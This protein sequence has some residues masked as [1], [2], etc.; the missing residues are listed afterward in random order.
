MKLLKEFGVKSLVVTPFSNIT[1]QLRKDLEE[2]FGSK[3]VGQLG[4]RR[5]KVDRLFTVANAQSASKVKPNTSE[6]DELS[7]CQV[8][9]FDESHMVPAE[10]FK[11]ICLNGVAMNAKKRFFL[12][13]TQTRTDGSELML[14]GITGPVV[15][16]KT[17]KELA[18]QKFLKKIKARIFKVP[19]ARP[20][21][22]DPN[23]ETRQ[24]L[25]ENPNVARL[26]ATLAEKAFTVANRQ[27]VIL[28]EEYSQFL[29]LKNFMNVPYKFA[30]GTVT[31]EQKKT[32]PEEYW[33]CDPEAIVDEFNRGDLPCIIGTTAIA[34]G[35]DIKPTG[36][37]INIQGGKSEIK[38]KQG[39]GRG[40]R[41]VGPEELWV[42]DFKVVGS[43]TLENHAESR[44]GIYETLSEEKVDEI[45]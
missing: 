2:A 20:T 5:K 7:R 27:T 19:P 1:N 33:K 16:K 9:I 12:S 22:N 30:H 10:S 40:T 41:P 6:W 31:K 44:K 29:L 23:K 3:Y 18:S 17:Y 14:K 39:V 28:I 26:A 11:N 37:L 43:R 42:C 35:V 24:N 32:L 38:V 4:D 45:G 13:A 25:Y 8:I 36:C 34:T 21:V 15:Y